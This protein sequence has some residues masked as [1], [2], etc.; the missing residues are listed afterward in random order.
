MNEM[1]IATSGTR[2]APRPMIHLRRAATWRYSRSEG[3]SGVPTSPSML[4]P[5]WPEVGLRSNPLPCTNHHTM[6]LR[7]HQARLADRLG[8]S[9]RVGRAPTIA[10]VATTE[11]PPKA[12]ATDKWRESY[13]AAPERRGELFSTMSGV[14]D[15]AL[16]TPETVPCD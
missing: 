9:A 7:H 6:V 15:E 11:E 3:A 14:E 10:S 2:T 5:L 16:Y 1:T 8:R 13:D 4:L 12:P